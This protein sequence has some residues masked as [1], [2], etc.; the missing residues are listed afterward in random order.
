MP[1]K[2]CQR[3]NGPA[4]ERHL[5]KHKKHHPF[6]EQIAKK[7]FNL[8]FLTNL[9]IYYQLMS[10]AR[11]CLNTKWYTTLAKSTHIIADDLLRIRSTPEKIIFF[12]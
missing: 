8:H 5:F 12:W 6:G 10:S 3:L 9:Y 1:F 11:L 2:G 7:K 4:G